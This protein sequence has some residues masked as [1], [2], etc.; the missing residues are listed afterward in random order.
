MTLRN[1][2]FSVFLR[3][4][5]L[6]WGT[7]I[8]KRFPLIERV[9]K[10]LF[11]HLRPAEIEL[12][13]IEGIRMYVKRGDIDMRLAHGA[14]LFS[15]SRDKL[16]LP[17]FKQLIKPGMT[18]LD[19]GAHVGYYTLLAAKLV[20]EKGRV[21]A[22]EPAPATY[23]LLIKNITINGYQNIVPIQKA[24]S[25][26]SGQV[27]LFL[28]DYNTGRHNI[29]DHYGEKKRYV[30]VDSIT[31]D[32]FFRGQD[33]SIDF[34]KMDIEGAEMVALQGMENLIRKTRNLKL[35]TEF[36]PNFLTGA[37]YSPEAFLR[38][39]TEHGFKLHDLNEETGI[40]EPCYFDSLLKAYIGREYTNLLGVKEE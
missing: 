9:F 4:A 29:Y 14:S 17:L 31:L 8:S 33:I 38:N 13:E 20:G 2:M 16:L 18:V 5:K 3:T 27:R 6:F 21:F 1:S 35:V 19:L 11:V 32:E 37:G 24:V 34:I 30:I 23:A 36:N 28:N 12:I 39:L 15:D 22:F 10:F 26:K 25:N 7:G 40:I